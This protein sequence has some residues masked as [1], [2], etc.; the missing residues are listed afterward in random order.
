[1]WFGGLWGEDDAEH[2]ACVSSRRQGTRKA[3]KRE[4][5]GFDRAL[6]ICC[7]CMEGRLGGKA[8]HGRESARK[9][10]GVAAAHFADMVN[11]QRYV[12][13]N[14]KRAVE[15]DNIFGFKQ[16]L[17]LRAEHAFYYENVKGCP[18]LPNF[19]YKIA[20]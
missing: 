20:P 5:H 14:D 16:P 3:Q 6:A 2:R 13:F 12:L 9:A 15:L 17:L 10:H 1:M 19:S 18:G 4:L 11:V 7:V 8:H